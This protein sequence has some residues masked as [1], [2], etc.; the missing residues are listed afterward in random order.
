MY[1]FF[2]FLFSGVGQILKSNKIPVGLVQNNRT[3]VIY[4]PTI[5][6]MCTFSY[7]HCVFFIYGTT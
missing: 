5:N 1:L 2:N 4:I 7:L 6:M 3:A